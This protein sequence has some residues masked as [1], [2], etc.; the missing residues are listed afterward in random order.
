[1]ATKDTAYVIRDGDAEDPAYLLW[2]DGPLY[3]FTGDRPQARRYVGRKQAIAAAAGVEAAMAANG[4]PGIVLDIVPA[5]G[6]VPVGR[7]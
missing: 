4:Y 5:R 2:A 7:P 1:M 3:R 6:G